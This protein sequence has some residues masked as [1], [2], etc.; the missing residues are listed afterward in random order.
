M[1]LINALVWTVSFGTLVF[2]LSVV[3]LRMHSESD[4]NSSIETV[5]DKHSVH[6]SQKYFPKSIPSISGAFGLF[7][8]FI[9]T[10]EKNTL[11]P[12]LVESMQGP[13][14]T[15]I[16]NFKALESKSKSSSDSILILESA[17]TS[18]P[19][20]SNSA[21][22]RV[23]LAVK[24]ASMLSSSTNIKI[25]KIPISIQKL[26]TNTDIPI[27]NLKLVSRK[28]LASAVETES[29]P[30]T[31]AT[32]TTTAAAATAGDEFQVQSCQESFQPKCDIYPYIK[33]WNKKYRSEDC[34]KSPLAHPLGKNAPTS[35]L[36]YLVFQ[37]DIGG[38]NNIRMAAEVAMIFAHATGR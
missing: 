2:L 9:V 14:A 23:V 5:G 24:S 30:A 25:A 35:E 36:K 6:L 18:E 21:A 26:E 33:F 20:K 15:V 28:M 38:W 16:F 3:V 34:Y 8:L 4:S 32:A 11:G 12:A 10:D 27:Q 1:K 7:N 19:V 22:P 37:P 13:K 31:T 17:I 29:T